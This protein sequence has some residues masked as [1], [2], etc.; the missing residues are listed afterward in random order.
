MTKI[1]QGLIIVS[2]TFMVAILHLSRMIYAS[3][4]ENFEGERLIGVLELIILLIMLLFIAIT[5]V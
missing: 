2:L 5:D 3:N 1:S 4:S